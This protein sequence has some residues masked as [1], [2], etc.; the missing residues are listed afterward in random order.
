[1]FSDFLA[2]TYEDEGRRGRAGWVRTQ[3]PSGKFKLIE[4]HA[5]V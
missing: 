2:Y 3:R 4:L 1:M 5:Y